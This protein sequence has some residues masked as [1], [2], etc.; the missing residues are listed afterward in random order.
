MPSIL[1]TLATRTTPLLPA[2][3]ESKIQV[4]VM[5][6]PEAL[7][8]ASEHS[9]FHVLSPLEQG[10]LLSA[11]SE[12]YQ[13]QYLF[14]HALA[15][16]KIAEVLDCLPLDL[17]LVFRSHQKPCFRG[18]LF[19][20]DWFLSLT[21]TEGLVAA[22][23]GACPVGVDVEKIRY[24]E[25][26]EEIVRGRGSQQETEEIESLSNSRDRQQFRFCQLWTLKEAL[27]K[28]GKFESAAV[29]KKCTFQVD[30]Q[31][32]LQFISHG[33]CD[34]GIHEWQFSLFHP[35][36]NRIMALAYQ[37]AKPLDIVSVDVTEEELVSFPIM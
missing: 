10:R 5:A 19:G 36:G 3:I 4:W 26:I 14:S 23:F 22:A 37:S 31:D 30:D 2:E 25:I 21:H 6:I 9:L 15:R 17:P 18:K 12:E 34:E 35:K 8:H 13:T 29:M 28:T 33:L 20:R 1:D 7:D 27:Y 24:H 11:G 32:R 16:I